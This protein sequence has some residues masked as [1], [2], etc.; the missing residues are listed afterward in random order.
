MRKIVIHSALAEMRALIRGMLSDIEALFVP[1]ASRD[2]LFRA[3]RAVKYDLV[4]TD[5][6]EMLLHD[7]AAVTKIRGI[8]SLPQI[9]VLSH[10][11][12][13]EGAVAL[14]AAGVNQIIALPVA[15]ERLYSKV[16]APYSDLV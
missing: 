3:C 12:S 15:P 11:L 8:E 10:N 6:V 7:R 1:V 2:E 4:L 16:S 5:D 9:F 13:E 14:L